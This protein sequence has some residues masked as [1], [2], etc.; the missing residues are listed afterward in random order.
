MSSIKS[1]LLV[2]ILL[3]SGL[4]LLQ[5]GC[6]ETQL[7]VPDEPADDWE[8]PGPRP[9]PPI[10][11]FLSSDR[12]VLVRGDAKTGK[13]SISAATTRDA[14]FTWSV[15]T[16]DWDHNDETG[17]AAKP[18]APEVPQ[19]QLDITFPDDTEPTQTSVLTIDE[20][21]TDPGVDGTKVNVTVQA[22]DPEA[23]TEGGESTITLTIVRPEAPLTLTGSTAEAKSTIVPGEEITLEAAI[24]G[25][26]PFSAESSTECAAPASFAGLDVVA[27]EG[28]GSP[29]C[30][31]W[32]VEGVQGTSFT[33]EP[34][35][36]EDGVTVARSTYHAPVETGN[37]TIRVTVLDAA[38][39]RDSTSIPIV[40]RSEDELRLSAFSSDLTVAP[41]RTTTIAAEV[42]GGTPPYTVC[43]KKGD[44][45]TLVEGGTLATA[46]LSRNSACEPMTG[47]DNCS[48]QEAGDDA[49]ERTYT[50]PADDTGTDSIT[51]RVQDSVGDVATSVVSLTVAAPKRLDV[52]LSS[53]SPAIQPNTITELSANI[54]GGTPP[55]TV[56]YGFRDGTGLGRL[57][58][59]E[60]DCTPD[61]D[62]EFLEGFTKCDCGV[63]NL[64]EDGLEDVQV[65]RNYS[66]PAGAGSDAIVVRVT[67]ATGAEGSSSLSINISSS[68]GGSGGGTVSL[69][70]SADHPML[71][72]SDGIAPEQAILTATTVG[73]SGI[74]TYTFAFVGVGPSDDKLDQIG[75]PTNQR[76]Y[77]PS[78]TQALPRKI[79]VIVEESGGSRA[80]VEYE[81]RT[82]DPATCQDGNDCTGPDT[83]TFGVCNNDY[84]PA[85]DP[86]GS[87]V[88]DDCT[89]PDKCDGAGVCLANHEAAGFSCGNS[90]NGDCTDPD[91]CDGAGTCLDNHEADGTGCTDDGNEC[92]VD[93]CDA[94]TCVHPNSPIGTSCGDQTNTVCTN[95]DTCNGAGVCLD[96]HAAAGTSCGSPLDDACTD[97]DTCDGGVCVPNHAPDGTSCPDDSNDCTDDLCLAGVCDHQNLPANTPCGS[98]IDDECTDPDTCDGVGVC[99]AN[100]ETSGTPCGDLT[101]DDCTDPDTCDGAGSCLDNHEADG[102][103]C[104]ADTND[105]TNDVCAAGVCNHPNSPIGTSCGDQTNTVC[106]NPDTCNGAGVCLDNHA[107]D[108]T[109]CSGDGNDCTDDVCAAGSCDHPYMPAGTPC[110]DQ[111]SGECDAANTCNSL[112]VCQNNPVA[113][114]APCSDD[115][116]DCTNDVCSNAVCTHPNHPPGT[117]CGDPT[118]TTC[119][120]A[121]TCNGAGVCMDNFAS[122][123]DLCGDSSITDCTAAD[124][125]DGAGVCLGN[126]EAN[127]TACT[128]DTNDCTDDV[129]L[130]GN[131][132][133]PHSVVG[134]LCGDQDNTVCTNPDTCNGH[135]V[136][137][138]NHEA[139]GTLC[140][141]I[142][143]SDCDNPDTCNG[144]GICASNYEASGT[145]CGDPTDSDCDNPDTCDGAGVCLANNEPD[146]TACPDEGNDCTD[147][148]CAA[149][150]CTHPDLAAGTSCGD[151]TDSDCDD[152]DTC[153]GAG[154]CLANNEPD[155]TACPDEGNDCTDDLCAAAVCTHPDLAAGTSCGDPTDSDCDDPDTCDGAGVCLANNEPDGTACPDEGNDCTDDLCAAAVCTHPDLA[156]GT[157]CGDPTDSDC[158]DPDT[159]DG[160]GVCLANNEPDGTACPDEGNDCTDDLCAAAVCTHPDLAAGTSC[161]DPT[162]SD[163]DNPDTCDGAGVCLA[164][165]E[166][167]GTACPDEGNDCTDD[168]CAAAVCTHP[169]LAA[170]TPC[171]DPT[172]DDCTDPDSCD[173]FGL[174]LDN[175]AADT[176]P[177]DTEFCM[178][179]QECTAGIC[180]GGTTR[181]CADTLDCTTDTCDEVNDECDHSIDA[182]MCS[183]G[184]VCYTDGDLNPANDCE[185]CN[186]GLDQEDWS[187]LVDGTGCL[188]CAGTPACHC[189]SGICIDD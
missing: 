143:D 85:G 101:D 165:N 179:N 83:C 176:T 146:G 21:L 15:A 16:A 156:A 91:T 100:H 166:P 69:A 12:T 33:A 60:S 61:A 113:N 181:D 46:A 137:L 130:A 99:L 173:G 38:G 126:H 136:C 44:A 3:A 98:G 55:Y 117:A 183:I 10:T 42:A 112:G 31:F 171:G 65:L 30:V 40:V 167:D 140:G 13:V 122:F 150:V 32:A 119:N 128:P 48:C 28:N 35:T 77:T 74:N 67:D 2:G 160:A 81:I 92:T 174:C 68:H 84:L 135:G 111:S 139:S 175:H 170:G 70:V 63:G 53:A 1:T 107:A 54:S 121:D 148:L 162:D 11:V 96:N 82:T 19:A 23:R 110:G 168:L 20:V 94:G 151:P 56:C 154:V 86:C 50:A 158:D 125:C 164:N 39:N 129:C 124:T 52:E 182:G 161:G 49:P 147:D 172:D 114:G 108:D 95:P 72:L 184:V 104:T 47:Y 76:R 152:P 66:A 80:E 163:C 134:T 185:E 142:V 178:V 34:L 17:F 29:Y 27:P 115:G 187:P 73:G 159:C 97:P 145:A 133:H 58:T 26:S 109:P 90:D 138:D 127:G 141:S 186:S 41:R 4:L 57:A 5:P 118:D 22:T 64:D 144:A 9:L 105:C 62:D 43:F 75:L 180:G 149:A 157:S 102:T 89:N 169:D 14:I 45:D 51:V 116:N 188:T 8:E 59:R 36:E 18:G 79:K 93:V 177:C 189:D 123:G 88:D 155:G 25:G 106:T 131:C 153:D 37:V 71:C 132:V 103:I 120:P 6:Y 7:V 78:E 87:T 24:S